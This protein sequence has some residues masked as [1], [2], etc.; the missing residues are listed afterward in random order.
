M[1]LET[2]LRIAQGAGQEFSHAVKTKMFMTGAAITGLGPTA[3][4]K[5]P[6]ILSD[7]W[8]TGL[9]FDLG[10]YTFIIQIVGLIFLILGIAQRALDVWK[11]YKDVK[12]TQRQ[13]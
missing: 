9:G 4:E 12:N 7:N 11:R 10:D 6:N 2:I 1:K 13:E 8:F 3:A 5:V